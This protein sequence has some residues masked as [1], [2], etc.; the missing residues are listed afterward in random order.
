[1]AMEMKVDGRVLEE[2]GPTNSEIKV[3]GEK[4]ESRRLHQASRAW[5][6]V[7][8]CDSE[9][10]AAQPMTEATA[11]NAAMVGWFKDGH[12]ARRIG[13]S[14]A[15]QSGPADSCRPPGH[16]ECTGL[17]L[18]LSRFQGWLGHFDCYRTAN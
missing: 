10:E 11:E 13:H 8:T 18:T 6:V 4:M 2:F 5:V 1:M 7:Q 16:A 9:T 17:F 12:G 15:E 14:V 3:L